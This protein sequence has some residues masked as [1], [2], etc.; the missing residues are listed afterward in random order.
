[1]LVGYF[2]G[3][4]FDGAAVDFHGAAAFGAHKVMVVGFR[5]ACAVEGFPTGHVQHVYGVNVG[6]GLQCAVHGGQADFVVAPGEFFVDFF[7]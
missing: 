4:A 2:A 6:Q 3:P 1:M 5:G 7:G